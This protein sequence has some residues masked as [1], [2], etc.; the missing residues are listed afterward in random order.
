MR[1]FADNGN[2]RLLFEF[3]S[4]RVKAGGKALLLNVRYSHK[5]RQCDKAAFQCFDPPFRIS[6]LPLHRFDNP[7]FQNFS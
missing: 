4:D 1:L 5:I 3:I 6:S 2:Q 7:P